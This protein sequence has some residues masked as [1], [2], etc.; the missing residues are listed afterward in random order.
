MHPD[1]RQRDRVVVGLIY[2]LDSWRDLDDVE[3]AIP[4][5]RLAKRVDHVS[6]CVVILR[7]SDT[8]IGHASRVERGVVDVQR[9]AFA[10]SFADRRDVFAQRPQALEREEVEPFG[11]LFHR[12]NRVG[13]VAVCRGT[14]IPF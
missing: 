7:V 2:V 3:G 14:P 12:M 11:A 6:A 9:Y 4:E 8:S 13:R 1:G 10:L 5:R